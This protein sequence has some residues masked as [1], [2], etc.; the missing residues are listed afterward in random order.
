[1]FWVVT[2]RTL[3]LGGCLILI[4]AI[5]IVE[6]ITGWPLA[7][8]ESQAVSSS[9]VRELPIYS[10]ETEERKIAITFDAAAG[11]SD[12]D[13]LLGILAA[14]QVKA[15]FFLCGCWIRNHPEETKKIYNAGHEIGN[16]GDQHLDPAKLEREELLQEM[17]GQKQEMQKLLGITPTLYRPAYGS[18]TTE[19]IRAARA[20]GYE[21]VQ[22]SVDSLDWQDRSA[23]EI[24]DTVLNHR[25]L[26]NGAILLFHNDTAYT[27]QA[28]DTLLTA[29]EKEG[30]QM[31]CVSDLIW[32]EP[33]EIDHTG[34]QFQVS[35]A[36]SLPEEEGA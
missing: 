19:V 5:C 34:R 6:G 26:K 4:L 13:A 20:S 25:D 29:L 15:T 32:K 11:A 27:A 17:E 24:I 28:L 23:E 12:T 3:A 36:E 1:M 22:W 18:Y 21:A 2:K 14:H 8:P 16:H 9:G 33:Y 10:V 30:Y 35:K 31:V 7:G